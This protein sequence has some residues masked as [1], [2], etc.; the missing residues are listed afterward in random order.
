MT[1]KGAISYYTTRRLS[2]GVCLNGLYQSLPVYGDAGGIS[3]ASATGIGA[4]DFA[5]VFRAS[6]SWTVSAI[7]KNLGADM[8]WQMGEYAPLVKD[9]PLPAMVAAS[10]LQTE[11]FKK[12]LVW[13]LDCRGYLFDGSWK[14]LNRPEAVISSG[15]EWRRWD[16]LF[17]RAGIGDLSLTGDITGDPDRYWRQFGVRLCAGFS[18]DLS[19]RVRKGLWINYGA[20][21]DKVWA[22]IEQQLDVTYSF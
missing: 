2:V 4:L 21:T 5:V 14:Q 19:K 12:P 1:F 8:E 16:N 22:G 3:S 17:V 6:D 20:A 15:A 11:F 9:Q 13:L 18:Y 7:A 10:C